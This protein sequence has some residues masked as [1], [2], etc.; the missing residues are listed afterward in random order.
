MKMTNNKNN[1][2]KHLIYFQKLL[3]ELSPNPMNIDNFI[4]HSFSEIL[5]RQYQHDKSKKSKE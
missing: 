4:Q 1:I 2:L 3:R 5:E